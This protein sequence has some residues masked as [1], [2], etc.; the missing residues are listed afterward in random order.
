[1]RF[2]WMVELHLGVVQGGLGFEELAGGFREIETTV[3]DP[4]S[5]FLIYY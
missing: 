3:F 4:V 5:A 2:R 1:M